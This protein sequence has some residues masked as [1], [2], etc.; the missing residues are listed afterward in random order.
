MELRQR[1]TLKSLEN[2]RLPQFV[3]L[4]IFSDDPYQP[5]QDAEPSMTAIGL[6]CRQYLGAKRDDP[7]LSGGASTY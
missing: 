2:A 5:G 3:V 4:Q 6:L 1:T 7:I